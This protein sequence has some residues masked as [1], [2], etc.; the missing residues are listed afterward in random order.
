[1]DQY[2]F[3]GFGGVAIPCISEVVITVLE[4][5]KP[6]S[7]TVRLPC[8]KVGPVSMDFKLS[9]LKLKTDD[10]KVVVNPVE[11]IDYSAGEWAKY[12]VKSAV[13]ITASYLSTKENNAVYRI[14][15]HVSESAENYS[16]SK[17]GK[18]GT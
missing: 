15:A 10:H 9:A 17:F 14:E 11:M 5:T 2:D 12:A 13:A 1:M 18:S 16:P 4:L 6:N 8:T 7:Y 3:F